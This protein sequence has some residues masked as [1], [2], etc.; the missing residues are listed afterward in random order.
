VVG[1]HNHT[2]AFLYTSDHNCIEENGTF[3][4]AKDLLKGMRL[5]SSVSIEDGVG[6]KFNYTDWFI[7]LCAWVSSE[8]TYRKD[9]SVLIY[10]SNEHNPQY[11]LEI[12]RLLQ[13]H[14]CLIKRAQYGAIVHWKFS[15]ELAGLIRSLMPN[16]YP[17]MEFVHNMRSSQ[18]RLFLYEYLR[19]DGS[20]GG[21]MPPKNRIN[22]LRNFWLHDRKI[23]P[24]ITS[25]DKE[26]IDV[27]QMMATLS[28][29]NTVIRTKRQS[30]GSFGIKQKYDLHLLKR[31]TSFK[32]SGVSG[33]HDVGMAWCPTTELGTWV[34]RRHGVVCITGNSHCQ[35]CLQY[36][37]MF[38]LNDKG[39]VDNREKV[40]ELLRR[41]PQHRAADAVAGY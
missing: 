28:G 8:G 34:S 37:A 1:N 26:A 12:D 24:R 19:G 23:T 15:Y 4:K 9:G 5:L 10:Q 25:A 33:A 7:K 13:D 16:K 36:S 40:R 14:Q 21:P 41:A 6:K 29:I 17:N 32:I 31:Q 18:R 38:I 11:V 35:D 3:I 39:K 27:L 22:R 20:Y 30:H 2:D